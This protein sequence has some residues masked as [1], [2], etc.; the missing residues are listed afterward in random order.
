MTKS[1]KRKK[2]IKLSADAESDRIMK[3]N[4]RKKWDS[5]TQK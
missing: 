2:K 5:I 3:E 1:E 4:L